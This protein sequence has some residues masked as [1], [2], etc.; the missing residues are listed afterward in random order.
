MSKRIRAGYQMVTLSPRETVEQF[1]AC[2]A[3]L[4]AL[5]QRVC[6]KRRG[7]RVQRAYCAAF[8]KL[9]YTWT[10][11]LWDIEEKHNY[12]VKLQRTYARFAEIDALLDRLQRALDKADQAPAPKSGV[13]DEPSRTYRVPC[14]DL[15]L[16]L[17]D[18]GDCERAEW[19]RRE[20]EGIRSLYLLP[21]KPGRRTCAR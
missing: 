20:R 17:A 15:D 6:E 11:T 13:I 16:V 2:I 8:N 10:D 7:L 1:N 18:P 12:P 3:R 9:G 21:S 4:Q 19:A 14:I 5:A